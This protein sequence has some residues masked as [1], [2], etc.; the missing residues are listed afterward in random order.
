MSVYS[1][2]TAAVS[3]SGA[4]LA[5]LNVVVV[6]VSLSGRGGSRSPCLSLVM[7]NHL[8]QHLPLGQNQVYE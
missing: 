5:S 3:Y 6:V 4:V 7:S 8:Q 2:N 1:E